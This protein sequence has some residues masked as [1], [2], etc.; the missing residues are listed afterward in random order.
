MKLNKIKYQYLKIKNTIN[1]VTDFVNY[2]DIL[3]KQKLEMLRNQE[4]MKN[5]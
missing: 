5:Y 3:R 1:F 2:I 4:N